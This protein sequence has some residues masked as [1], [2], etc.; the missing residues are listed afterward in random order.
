MV[1]TSEFAGQTAIDPDMARCQPAW[2]CC[3]W[4][5]LNAELTRIR[6]A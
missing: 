2:R 5:A 4:R 3:T 6:A 1:M